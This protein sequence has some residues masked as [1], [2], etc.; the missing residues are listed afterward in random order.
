MSHEDLEG[1][2]EKLCN[3]FKAQKD[4][5]SKLQQMHV[6]KSNLVEALVFFGLSVGVA[7]FLTFCKTDKLKAYLKKKSLPVTGRKEEQASRIFNVWYLPSQPKPMAY[8]P[9]TDLKNFVVTTRLLE[10]FYYEKFT[11]FCEEKQAS[12]LGHDG[13]NSYITHRHW[14]GVY[15][16]KKEKMTQIRDNLVLV[17]EM[18]EF[19]TFIAQDLTQ[20]IVEPTQLIEDATSNIDKMKDFL[21]TLH[22]STLRH[23]SKHH[24]VSQKGLTKKADVLD[25]V[26]ASLQS[27]SL[28]SPQELAKCALNFVS[29]H[30]QKNPIGLYSLLSWTGKDLLLQAF[31]A[32]EWWAPKLE[33]TFAQMG[34]I[35]VTDRNSVL[36]HQIDPLVQAFVEISLGEQAQMEA[37]LAGFDQFCISPGKKKAQEK[38]KKQVAKDKE[39][40]KQK[41]MEKK[42]KPKRPVTAFV[43]F[44]SKYRPQALLEQPAISFGELSKVTGAAWSKLSNKEKKALE[45]EAAGDKVRYETEMEEWRKTQKPKK[46]LSAY[47]AFVKSERPTIAAECNDFATT[48]RLMGAAWKD[49]APE[50][51]LFFQRIADEDKQRYET[52]MTAWLVANPDK[53][54]VKKEPKQSKKEVKEEITVKIEGAEGAT[55]AESI[56][57]ADDMPPLERA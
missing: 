7:K 17:D 50:Q 10:M 23:Y 40:K 19:V 6:I 29:T 21:A 32:S 27:E 57:I 42:L 52:D 56:A 31:P 3:K 37:M 38:E 46:P 47:A 5:Y 39:K 22:G 20:A 11:A 54:K 14:H 41:A 1:L 45:K 12:T 8:E 25:S 28:C 44:G 35:D 13:L 49:M 36:C 48:S 9:G 53:R 18:R 4:D 43:L 30:G 16:T 15:G 55:A 51:K 24:G 34:E 26:V 33:E 2:Q